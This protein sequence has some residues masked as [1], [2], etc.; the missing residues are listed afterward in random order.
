M[1]LGLVQVGIGCSGTSVSEM[2]AQLASDAPIHEVD[3]NR[4]IWYAGELV[5]ESW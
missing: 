5:W 4:D 1:S 2:P 3:S